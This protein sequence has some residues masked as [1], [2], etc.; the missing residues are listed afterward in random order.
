MITAELITYIQQELASGVLPE[1]IKTQL[2]TSGWSEKDI[3]QA[4]VTVTKSKIKQYSTS[5]PPFLQRIS[6]EFT[7]I[8]NQTYKIFKEN[9]KT[10]LIIQSFQGIILLIYFLS[11]LLWEII[12]ESS[13][14]SIAL[15]LGIPITLGIIDSIVS[16]IPNLMLLYVVSDSVHLKGIREYTLQA[17]K[18]IWRFWILLFLILLYSTWRTLLLILV[19]FL[20]IAIFGIFLPFANSFI[21]I[22]Y[23]ISIIS[24]AILTIYYY[25]LYS[26]AIYVFVNERVGIKES[27]RRSSYY[28]S[29]N[30]LRILAHGIMLSLVMV[31][32]LFIPLLGLFLNLF[33]SVPVVNIYMNEL[34]KNIK[35]LRSEIRE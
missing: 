15:K 14:I 6:N 29:G 11:I 28:N 7:T 9:I 35:M 27:L 8:F 25:T 5:S 23:P 33:I 32:F 12:I 24:G 10:Y 31:V 17:V 18:N 16:V 1:N 20:I 34:Y 30:V 2:V 13:H 3:Q 21:I 22:L 4:F 26:F 19:A